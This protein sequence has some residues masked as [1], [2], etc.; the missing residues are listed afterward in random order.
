MQSGIRTGLGFD[1]GGA[2]CRTMR[3]RVVM[4]SRKKDLDSG[5]FHEL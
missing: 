2:N 5:P 1:L 4:V 3:V